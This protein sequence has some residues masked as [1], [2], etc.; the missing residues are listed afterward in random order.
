MYRCNIV[1]K[2]IRRKRAWRK[3]IIN[4]DFPFFPFISTQNQKNIQTLLRN[5]ENRRSSHLFFFS[6]VT[7]NAG[8]AE[9]MFN[10]SFA[11]SSVSGPRA[12]RWY[13][14]LRFSNAFLSKNN[15]SKWTTFVSRDFP[16]SLSLSLSLPR[17]LF[18]CTRNQSNSRKT[19]Q[20]PTGSSGYKPICYGFALFMLSS[21][22]PKHKDQ[23]C[24]HKPDAELKAALASGRLSN[25]FG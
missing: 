17:L 14:S 16:L 7:V 5:N 21:R 13:F 10:S 22:A 8:V 24:E 25:E 4:K 1:L 23:G 18:R 11:C 12:C 2:C 15:I 6:L 9:G 3:Q 20:S 19:S